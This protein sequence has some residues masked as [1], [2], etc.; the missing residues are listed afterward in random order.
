[1]NRYVQ[2][3]DSK[4]GTIVGPECPACGRALCP[5]DN[6]VLTCINSACAFYS[7]GVHREPPHVMRTMARY[8]ISVDEGGQADAPTIESFAAAVEAEQDFDRACRER[9]ANPDY[10]GPID[11]SRGEP[12][13]RRV[14]CEECNGSG[15][16]PDYDGRVIDCGSCAGTGKVKAR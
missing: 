16:W 3:H 1:M 13:P 15:R 8:A 2:G 5:D 6:L 11:L 12:G 14:D 7:P 4:G 10:A 9:A